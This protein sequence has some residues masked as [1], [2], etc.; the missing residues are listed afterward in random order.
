MTDSISIMVSSSE[1]TITITL[2]HYRQ[3]IN[4]WRKLLALERAGV[5]NWEWYDEAMSS[6]EIDKEEDEKEE[7]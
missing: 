3:L 1:E 2:K 5:D 6:L 7:S 4:A